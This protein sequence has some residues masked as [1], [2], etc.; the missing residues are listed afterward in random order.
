MSGGN[1]LNWIRWYPVAS[2]PFEHTLQQNIRLQ[3]DI[4]GYIAPFLRD[5]I[6][7]VSSVHLFTITTSK[8]TVVPHFAKPSGWCVRWKWRQLYKEKLMQVGICE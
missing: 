7:K 8:Q 6:E 1:W 5:T 4:Y 2:T 3:M